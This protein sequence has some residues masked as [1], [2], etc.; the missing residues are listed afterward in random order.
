MRTQTTAGDTQSVDHQRTARVAPSELFFTDKD[1]EEHERK[2]K[3]TIDGQAEPGK[4]RKLTPVPL[5]RV[6]DDDRSPRQASP[7]EI[8]DR[9]R[10][11]FTPSTQDESDADSSDSD[12][13]PSN[14]LGL[15]LVD[16]SYRALP[17]RSRN[18]ELTPRGR[19]QNLPKDEKLDAPEMWHPQIVAEETG[20]G[21]EVAIPHG[22]PI[23]FPRQDWQTWK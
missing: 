22:S 18:V 2:A 9:K 4:N 5:P 16:R 17:R 1:K 23:A 19:T 10:V 15:G 11:R 6:T 20:K 21:K 8:Q 3:Q 7:L 12:S 13:T 14:S